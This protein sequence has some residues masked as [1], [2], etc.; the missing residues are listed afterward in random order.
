MTSCKKIIGLLFAAAISFDPSSLYFAH[1]SNFNK[2]HSHTGKVEPFKPGDPNIKLD[3]SATSILKSGKP[4]QTQILSGD[5]GGRGLVVQDVDAPTHI[6]WDRILDYDNYANMVPKTLDSKNY[7]VVPHKPT[8]ANN[9]LE[10]EIYTRMKVGFPMIKLEFFVR[11]FLHIKEHKS[12]TWTLD[13]TKESDFDDSCGFWYIIPHPDDPEGRTRLYYSVQVGMF[14]WVPKF[15]VDF[16][17]S[18]ALTDATAWVKKYS[19]IE[20]VKAKK[21]GRAHTTPQ[22]PKAE[23]PTF[24]LPMFGKKKREEEE[25][26]VKEAA[27]K[28]AL[29][30]QAEAEKQRNAVVVRAGWRRYVMVSV[31]VALAFYNGSMFVG[32]HHGK[33]Q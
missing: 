17:S 23:A 3:G 7:K 6:V 11:H 19:E 28:A 9:F 16:M 33:S 18:K 15:A 29:E 5:A 32:D 12:L 10:K 27:E 24:A 13:Y 21:E 26:L 22:Q 31:M 20:W 14:D 30:E 8:K 4:Y 1:A 25:R 2:P